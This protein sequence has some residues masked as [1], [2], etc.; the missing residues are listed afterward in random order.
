MDF[1]APAE[2]ILGFEYVAK[3][4]EDKAAIEAT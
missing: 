2:D 4:D 1:E 3:T